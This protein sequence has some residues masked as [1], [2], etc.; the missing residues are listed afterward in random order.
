MLSYSELIH[1]DTSLLIPLLS[2]P[3]ERTYHHMCLQI[4]IIII[5]GRP[6]AGRDRND[7]GLISGTR[8]KSVINITFENAQTMPILGRNPYQTPPVGLHFVDPTKGNNCN[9][10]SRKLHKEVPKDF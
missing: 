4:E 9:Q 1:N 6:R 3:R 2:A 10:P 7:L 5:G 8:R